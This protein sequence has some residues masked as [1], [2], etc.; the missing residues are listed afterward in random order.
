MQVDDVYQNGDMQ[1]QQDDGIS[2]DEA[3]HSA[4]QSVKFA[5]DDKKKP[6]SILKADGLKSQAK[7]ICWSLTFN[8]KCN[9]GD[10]CPNLH[11][12]GAVVSKLQDLLRVWKDKSSSK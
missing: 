10:N 3:H 8:G 1:E 9:R 4:V 12:E 11:D 2:M 6:Y 5:F 7:E